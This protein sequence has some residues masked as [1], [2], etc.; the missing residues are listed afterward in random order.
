MLGVGCS[1]KNESTGKIMLLY[2]LFDTTEQAFAPYTTAN[3]KD[4]YTTQYVR[5]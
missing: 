2:L 4:Y 3:K 5:S 1:T